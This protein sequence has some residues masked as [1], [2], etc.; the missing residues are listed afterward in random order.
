MTG[1]LEHPN[2]VPIYDVARDGTGALFYAMKR[3]YGTPWDEGNR[4]E[5]ATGRTWRS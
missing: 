1:E 2:I 5:V 4:E 3:I